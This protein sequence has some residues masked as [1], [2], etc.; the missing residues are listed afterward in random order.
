MRTVH[1]SALRKARAILTYRQL[2]AILT[3][4]SARVAA[5]RLDV[6]PAT[7]RRWVRELDYAEQKRLRLAIAR[8]VRRVQHILVHRSA[9]M[10]VVRMHRFIRVLDEPPWLFEYL[11]VKYLLEETHATDNSNVNTRP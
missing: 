5:E 3:A 6:H 7:V 8:R 10:D 2:R 11:N 4:P 1:R 9:Q